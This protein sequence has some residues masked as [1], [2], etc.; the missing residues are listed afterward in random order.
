MEERESCQHIQKQWHVWRVTTVVPTELHLKPEEEENLPRHDQDRKEGAGKGREGL[1]VSCT[2]YPPSCH[3][4]PVHQPSVLM[5]WQARPCTLSP[6]SL[7]EPRSCCLTLK[8]ALSY[9]RCFSSVILDLHS[10]WFSFSMHSCLP[11]FLNSK[12]LP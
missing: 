8:P 5:V 6:L 10:F 3:P 7:G 12:N 9:P 4:L 2:L 1:V 11:G